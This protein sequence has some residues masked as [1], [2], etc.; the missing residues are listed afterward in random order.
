M[1]VVEHGRYRQGAANM[2][3]TH[4]NYR[5]VGSDV[6]HHGTWNE[7]EAQ[8]TRVLLCNGHRP[9]EVTK[10]PVTCPECLKMMRGM[11]DRLRP[12]KG[13]SEEDGRS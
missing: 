11:E 9:A 1:D 2:N 3:V 6:V 13:W 10:E 8:R 5:V 4:C 12:G 7:R